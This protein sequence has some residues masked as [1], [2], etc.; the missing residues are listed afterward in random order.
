MQ[1]NTLKNNKLELQGVKENN[2]K[3][4]DISID[5]NTFNV[6]TGTSGSGK[7]SLAFDTIHA[8]GGRRYIETFSPYTRQFLDRL[9]QPELKS[10]TGVRASLALEQRNRITSSR[11]TVG[12][13]TEINDYLK[14]I[15]SESSILVC[16]DCKIEVKK[17]NAVSIT[18]E[19]LVSFKNNDFQDCVITFK[20]NIDK[21]SSDSLLETLGKSGFSRIDDKE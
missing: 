5:H 20:V 10:C 1:K 16:P 12:T 19:I 9:K 2:L 14:I 8:E 15:W 11:S 7:T 21:S 17:K 18:N 3:N 6:I 13:I 4:I